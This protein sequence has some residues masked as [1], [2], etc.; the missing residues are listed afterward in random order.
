MKSHEVMNDK[1][2]EEVMNEKSYEVM[3]EKSLSYE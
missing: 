1:S 2:Y 3:N